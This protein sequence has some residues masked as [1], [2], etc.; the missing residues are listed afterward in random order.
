MHDHAVHMPLPFFP[1]VGLHL[2]LYEKQSW[3]HAGGSRAGRLRHI[4]GVAC[5]CVDIN[6]TTLTHFFICN[7]KGTH[8]IHHHL[9]PSPLSLSLVLLRS[10]L[11]PL[12][13]VSMLVA[14]VQRCGRRTRKRGQQ[15]VL[16]DMCSALQCFSARVNCSPLAQ[17]DTVPWQ[18]VQP[19]FPLRRQAWFVCTFAL[20]A[21]VLLCLLAPICVPHLAF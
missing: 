12:R 18:S 20:C 19:P 7:L 13:C 3:A 10:F 17:G 8:T 21:V 6:L 14:H 5:V 15:H 1:T 2:A 9:F 11:F 16:L 4:V